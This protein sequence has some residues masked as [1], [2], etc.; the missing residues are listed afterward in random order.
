MGDASGTTAV[1]RALEGRCTGG[2][3][4]GVRRR[5]WRVSRSSPWRESLECALRVPL[6]R[7]GLLETVVGGAL[8]LA[9]AIALGFAFYRR[10]LELDLS[11]F[12]LVTGLLV[13]AFAGYLLVGLCTSSGR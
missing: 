2:R 13:I 4:G 3:G 11:K 7:R 6:G 9:V 10:S 1:P 5:P 8:G 12:F